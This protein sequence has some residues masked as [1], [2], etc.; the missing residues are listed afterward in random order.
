MKS[1][2]FSI[3]LLI[4]LILVAGV[5]YL[6]IY[7]IETSKL[8]NLI[9]SE[10][11]KKD[12]KTEIEL[13]KIKIKLNLKKIQLFLSTRSPKI[14]YH[15]TEIPITEIKVYSNI[16]K[17][18]KSQIEVSKI[19]FKIERFKIQ[20][21]QKIST[22]IKP[23]NFKTYLLNNLQEGEIEKALFDLNINK[24]FKLIDYKASGVVKEVNAKIVEVEKKSAKALE[25]HNGYLKELGLDTI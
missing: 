24:D 21:I 10:I 19:I 23:S 18:L 6:S 3:F 15:G 5:A 25:E 2:F 13:E 22:R 9:I 11:K 14:F 20:D 4:I 7:G 1:F 12:S 17:I 16:N 8:N